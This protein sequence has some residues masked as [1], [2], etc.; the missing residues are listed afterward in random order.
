MRKL[1]G[2]ARSAIL[3]TDQSTAKYDTGKCVQVRRLHCSPIQ[4]PSSDRVAALSGVLGFGGDRGD[5][6][7]LSF[8]RGVGLA[9]DGEDPLPCAAAHVEAPRRVLD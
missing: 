4:E 8:A 6:G 2:A 3:L 5:R 9:G 7:L 1:S